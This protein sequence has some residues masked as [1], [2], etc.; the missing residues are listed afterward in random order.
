MQ[1]WWDALR[2]LYR[3]LE[4]ADALGL[5]RETRRRLIVAIG[6]LDNALLNCATA[7]CPIRSVVESQPREGAPPGAASAEVAG[8]QRG[9][10]STVAS[11]HN[12]RWWMDHRADA[13]QRGRCLLTRTE[14][15]ETGTARTMAA[16][17]LAR[18]VAQDAQIGAVLLT[19]RSYT[20]SQWA[21]L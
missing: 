16:N 10:D 18:A 21:P 8:V 4:D 17:T 6:A 7:D 2:Q 12:C 14:A 13:E 20:C 9:A 11:C 15:G 5:S 3:M 1:Q 19:D